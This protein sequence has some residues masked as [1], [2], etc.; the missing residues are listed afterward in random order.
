MA[1]WNRAQLKRIAIWS[2][3][4]L[5]LLGLG[6]FLF[7]ASGIYSVAASRG[8]FAV[9]EWFLEFALRRSVA[10][11]SYGI[12]APPLEDPDMVRLGAGHFEGG[13]APC[14]GA[15]RK[16]RNAI[17]RQMLPPPPDLAQSVP[18]WSPEHLFWIV[19]NGLKYTGM[20]AWVAP[21]RDDEV[22]AVVAFL[23]RL[24]GMDATEYRRLASGNTDRTT[25][26]PRERTDTDSGSAPLAACARCHG[27]EANPPASSLV[28]RLAGQSSRYLKSAMDDYAA[29]LRPSGI[30]Q[31]VAAELDAETVTRLAE[32]Y[33]GLAVDGAKAP[34]TTASPEK[35]EGGRTIAATGVPASGI[36]PCLVCHVRGSPAVFPRL[37]GQYARYTVGQLQ[38]WR[39][40]LRDRSA[41]GAIMAA[42]AR[43]MT[44]R[45]IEDVA[46]YFESLAPFP[47]GAVS[48]NGVTAAPEAL[49]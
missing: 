41:R 47:V 10:T 39:K 1:G 32:Y 40:G 44:D 20:P 19:Q 43:R 11:H 27:D 15:P 5:A 30:M 31:P 23:R 13:C 3:A 45:Q 38:L 24:P 33:A 21:R 29:G 48:Q 4:T 26:A 17:V 34:T 46:A 36:P 18:T 37:A 9:T 6:A 49:P 16:P 42:I 22:W 25:P 2:G 7:A 14:H 12:T 28:P 35:I 8:H